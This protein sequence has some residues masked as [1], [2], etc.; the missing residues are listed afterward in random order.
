EA[1]VVPPILAEQFEL[2]HSLINMMNLEQFFGLK[3]DNLHDLIR[4]ARRW[5][6]K[7][8]PRS[9]TTWDDLLDTFYNALNP[10]DQDSLNAA[11]DGNFLEKN[12]QDA[13]T[14]IENKSKVRNSRSKPIA[15]P[16]NACDINS[17]SEIAKLT[18]AVNQQTS[19]M[20]AMLKQLQ[21]NPPLAQVK[22]VE[23]ICVTCGA[24]GNY[25]Q[26]NPGYRPQ[27]VANQMRPPGFAQPNVQNNQNRFGQPQGFNRGT[28]FNQEQPYQATAQSNQNFHLNDLEKIKRMND[29]S[30][31]AMQN[32]IDMMNT[33]STSGSGSLPG[34]TVANP[35]GKLKAITTRSGLVTNGPT[36]PTPPRSVT[37]EDDECVKETYMDLDLTEYTIKKMLKA[38]LSNKEKLQELANT[39]LNENCSAVILKKLPEKLGDPGKFLIS[40]GFSLPD[41]IPTRMTLE[42]AN[43]AIC[44]P[45]GIARDV[46]VPVGKFTFPADFVV[47]DYESNPRV[48]LILGRPFLRTARAIIDVHGEEMILRD[49]DERLTLNMKHDTASYSNHPHR[50]SVNLINIFNISSEDC[51]EV[52]VLN[53]KSGNPTFSL[54]K[55]ITSPKV[56]HE[57]HDSKGCNFLSEELPDIDSFNDI[58]PHFDDDLLSGS[59][60]YSSNSEIEFLLY[61][62]EDYDLK[63][64]IDQTDL[65]NLDDYFVNPTPEMFTDEHAPDY[66]FLPRFDGEK[67]KES[68]LLIDELDLPYD[69]L[70]YSEYDSFASQ[71][72]SR[73]DDLPSP[74]N[75]DKVF[76]PGI[77]IHEKSVTIITRV[78]QEKKLAISY[79]F[80]VFEDFKPPFYEL[81]VFKDVPNSMKLLPFSSENEENI[82]KPG[83]Y[84]F[85]K[86][87]ENQENNKI[88]SKPDKN[89]KRGEAKKSQSNHSQERKKN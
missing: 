9:I 75:E 84:T 18:H 53:K 40:C 50:E 31:K 77:L 22:A 29:V 7:E 79:D 16:V 12:P 15:S 36:I 59:T 24:A 63:D 65:A 70:P 54:H 57:I 89:R 80:L 13:L 68:E 11:V 28:N 45:D 14:I 58:H 71:D 74:D 49:G 39:P 61:Q 44:T 1:I 10:A 52:S 23:E 38:L 67:I 21:A 60:T 17:S 41:L 56:T 51:L 55:E 27:G 37:P 8:S 76:N 34:N 86:V 64:S 43:R 62:G 88:G 5:L 2:K 82:F 42:L 78:A 81:L 47:V 32:Q 25:N 73:D 69:I 4:A 48:P 46:F 6:E 72:F 19:A 26:G 87:K 20:T 3:K 66:S 83:I 35:K 33:A 30:I 85:E